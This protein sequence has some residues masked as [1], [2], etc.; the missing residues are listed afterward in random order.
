VVPT[1]L[2]GGW[3]GNVRSEAN[4]VQTP[5]F[6]KASGDFTFWLVFWAPSKSSVKAERI[7]AQTVEEWREEPEEL[8]AGTFSDC[9]R[10]VRLFFSSSTPQARIPERRSAC[11]SQRM[12]WALAHDSDTT[13]RYPFAEVAVSEDDR[14]QA[15]RVGQRLPGLSVRI[16]WSYE[17]AAGRTLVLGDYAPVLTNAG[18]ARANTSGPF[19]GFTSLDFFDADFMQ[20]ALDM[21]WH[22]SSEGEEPH[23][24]FRG[25]THSEILRTMSEC[26]P[27][28]EDSRANIRVDLVAGRVRAG[29]RGRAWRT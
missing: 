9:F 13:Q 14:E 27:D 4:Q 29:L 19:A 16:A 5:S 21:Q 22:S 25:E 7:I 1:Y 15:K 2:E 12:Q 3:H 8:V 26:S 28:C 17:L 24:L 20:H 18:L 6:T 23:G 11:L 10:R